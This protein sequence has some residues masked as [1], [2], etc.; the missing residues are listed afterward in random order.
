LFRKVV[1]G[2]HTARVGSGHD[3]ATEESDLRVGFIGKE[4]VNYYR[5]AS[6]FSGERTRPSRILNQMILT[7]VIPWSA[8]D[9]NLLPINHPYSPTIK[10]H[11]PATRFI[12]I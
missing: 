10:V 1:T 2:L 3:S 5:L 11:V 6:G 7:P 12:F 8:D 4:A 9:V